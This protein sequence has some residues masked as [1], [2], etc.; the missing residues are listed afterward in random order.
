MSAPRRLGQLATQLQGI[1]GDDRTV[2]GRLV[3]L[4]HQASHQPLAEDR[5][6][7]PWFHA[8]DFNPRGRARRPGSSRWPSQTTCRPESGTR[9]ADRPVCRR[10]TDHHV[11]GMRLAGNHAPAEPVARHAGSKRIHDTRQRIPQRH[12]LPGGFFGRVALV[13]GADGEPAGFRASALIRLRTALD[14]N[15]TWTRIGN[16]SFGDLG[17]RGPDGLHHLTHVTSLSR[18]FLKGVRSLWGHDS[19]DDG[20]R[21]SGFGVPC[22]TSRLG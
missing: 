3:N 4:K 17:C 20:W 8:L 10:R 9:P 11:V 2:A 19:I 6:G 12:G 15:L 1:H 21:G 22:S 18:R 5:D 14:A 7:I 16:W 13:V